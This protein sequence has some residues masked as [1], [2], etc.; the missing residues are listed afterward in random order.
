MPGI[1]YCLNSL[2]RLE[3]FDR[4]NTIK[5]VTIILNLSINFILINYR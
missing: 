3:N 2:E 5:Q 1:L 4:E